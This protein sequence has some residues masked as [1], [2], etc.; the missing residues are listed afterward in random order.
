M[1]FE[2]F[3][4]SADGANTMMQF[5]NSV[6]SGLNYGTTILNI[7]N[8]VLGGPSSLNL[9]TGPGIVILGGFYDIMGVHCEAISSCITVNI[10]VT[11]NGDLVRIHNVNAANVPGGTPCTGVITLASTNTPGNTIIGMVPVTSCTHLANGQPSGSNRDA[12]ITTE[13]TFNP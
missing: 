11:G 6:A 4:C 8:I 2:F 3:E 1:T 9:Q 10:P 13:M 5:G 7:R 12:A